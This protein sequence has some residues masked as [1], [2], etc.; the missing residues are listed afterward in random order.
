VVSTAAANHFG[1]AVLVGTGQ[2]EG[3]AIK[4]VDDMRQSEQQQVRR[5]AALLLTSSSR[6]RMFAWETGID[7]LVVM[8]S[9]L[10]AI[11]AEIESILA[12]PR[13][14]RYEYRQAM[15]EQARQS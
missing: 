3:G 4:T 6:N 11:V 2:D 13:L 5:T 9:H 10:D 7:G 8:P 14:S 12:R 1:V 15:V